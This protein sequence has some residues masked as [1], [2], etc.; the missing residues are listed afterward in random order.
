MCLEEVASDDYSS[1]LISASCFEEELPVSSECSLMCGAH[2]FYDFTM[3][4]CVTCHSSCRSCVA[5]DSS[6]CTSCNSAHYLSFPSSLSVGS[7]SPK[8]SSSLAFSLYLSNDSLIIGDGNSNQSR[9]GSTS[10]PFVS[11][12]DALRKADELTAP[13]SG[14]SV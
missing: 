4:Q 9:D 7:C 5:G 13:Y 3:R 11:L 1:A 6:S 14:A 12:P 8:A 10:N 2:E